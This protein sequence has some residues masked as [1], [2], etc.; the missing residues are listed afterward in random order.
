VVAVVHADREHL[1]RSRGRRAE[2]SLLDRHSLVGDRGASRCRV[3]CPP[4]E[5]LPLPVDGL[6]IMAE[7]AAGS[8]GD[9]DAAL[10]GDQGEPS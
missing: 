8:R 5:L 9:V 4:A 1:S 3:V 10:A 6:G 2:L 7:A